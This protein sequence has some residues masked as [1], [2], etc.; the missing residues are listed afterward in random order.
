M[1]VIDSLPLHPKNKMM[2]VSRYDTV[3]LGGAY[4]FMSYL[5]LVRSKT[6]TR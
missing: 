5:K 2:I 3:N 6:L 1:D 4:Q